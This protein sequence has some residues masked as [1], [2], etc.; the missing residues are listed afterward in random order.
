MEFLDSF[1]DWFAEE[2]LFLLKYGLIISNFVTIVFLIAF[3]GR[4]R[5]PQS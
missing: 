2:D 1:I 5:K 4:N 3:K